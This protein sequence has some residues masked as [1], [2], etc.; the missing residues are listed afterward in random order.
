M[1]KM[2]IDICTEQFPM[3]INDVWHSN[4]ACAKKP[5][6]LEIH[7]TSWRS[8]PPHTRSIKCVRT[9]TWIRY[10]PAINNNLLA[11]HSPNTTCH[12]PYKEPFAMHAHA[13]GTAKPTIRIGT[14]GPFGELAVWKRCAWPSISTIPRVDLRLLRSSP[15]R[16]VCGTRRMWIYPP[17]TP[18]SPQ[19]M[20][21]NHC[22]RP[23]AQIRTEGSPS[24]LESVVS[25]FPAGQSCK[26]SLTQPSPA[27]D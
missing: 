2:G 10:E 18:C 16:L 3:T 17:V 15:T 19:L 21:P 23:N 22:S 20:D 5:K 7:M 4:N 27:A 25:W 6:W 11:I 24:K 12:G 8:L 26:I 14:P 13:P 9:W 1:L